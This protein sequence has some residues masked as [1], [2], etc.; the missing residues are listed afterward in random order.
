MDPRAQ[1]RLR[2]IE[3]EM[4]RFENEISGPGL[5]PRIGFGGLAMAGPM[6]RPP[7]P[8]PP[9]GAALQFI[10]HVMQSRPPHPMM[11]A[12]LP[13]GMAPP[14]RQRPPPPPPPPTQLL[15]AYSAAVTS[16]ATPVAASG[17]V[18]EAAPTRYLPPGA[19]AAAAAAQ[20]SQS[21]SN[22][23]DRPLKKKR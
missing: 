8:M 14:L 19:V 17:P 6:L 7:M 15:Q 9:P 22:N 5:G 12:A 20:S 11:A 21:A 1:E 18:I 10:P 13:M 2:Q 4:A 16:T 3:M 23:L